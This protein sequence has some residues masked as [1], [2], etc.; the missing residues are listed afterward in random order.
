[1]NSPGLLFKIN[2][3][4][5]LSRNGMPDRFVT[6]EA[7]FKNG[8]LEKIDFLSLNTY[9]VQTVIDWEAFYLFACDYA[10]DMWNRNNVS[11]VHPNIQDIINQ[12]FFPKN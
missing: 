2:V 9:N 5:H 7:T 4:E 12:H 11:E 1:M 3:P 10:Q 8:L 6:T